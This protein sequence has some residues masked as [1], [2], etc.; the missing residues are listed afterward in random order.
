MYKLQ[1]KIFYSNIL[2]C[3]K[4]FYNEYNKYYQ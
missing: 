4:K 2:S 3:P 1:Q